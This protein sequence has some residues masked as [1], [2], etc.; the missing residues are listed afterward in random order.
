MDTNQPNLED[1][2]PVVPEEVSVP[3]IYHRHPINLLWPGIFS[4]LAIITI[5][6]TAISLPLM[7]IID[8]SLYLPHLIL[9]AG[10]FIFL[11]VS[12]FF[13]NWAFWFFDV[14]II[15]E[16][17]IRDVE[18]VRLFLYRRS[19]VDLRQVQDI[20]CEVSGPLANLFHFGNITIQ[21]AATAGAVKLMSIYE[22]YKAAQK[23]S[24]LVKAAFDEMSRP[25]NQPQE[26][27]GE[28]NE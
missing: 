15:N 25:E 11:V 23:I 28:N 17:K 24:V 13:M 26:G 5:I 7:G 14:W 6:S 10:I 3:L 21:S 4:V 18:L 9:F 12:T 20:R 16:E 27:H 19:E 8:A 22:P 2:Q 1:I